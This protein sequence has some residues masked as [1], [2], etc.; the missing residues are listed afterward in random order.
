MPLSVYSFF[1][2]LPVTFHWASLGLVS[3]TDSLH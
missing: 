3:Q 1:V 2:I